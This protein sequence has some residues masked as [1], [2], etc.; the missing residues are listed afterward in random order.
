MPKQ[1]T[2]EKFL[3]MWVKNPAEIETTHR[4]AYPIALADQF[5]ISFK[6]R[7]AWVAALKSAPPLNS[8]T[9]HK[10]KISV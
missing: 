5:F 10:L 6:A 2:I 8:Y 3:K 7:Q 4:V 1:P 9:L